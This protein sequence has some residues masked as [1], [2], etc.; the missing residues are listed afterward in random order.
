VTKY[1]FNIEDGE[2]TPDA[3]GTEIDTLAHAKCQA[4]R[5]A[6]QIIC[7]AAETFWDAAEWKMT[8]TDET[9]LT[10]FELLIFGTESA[11]GRAAPRRSM[12]DTDASPD[13]RMS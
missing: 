3:E 5:M 10:L 6:G 12:I 11:A 7:D 1:H 4:M 2:S 13:R 8:V 9:G